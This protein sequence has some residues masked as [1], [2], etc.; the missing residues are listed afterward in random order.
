[1]QALLQLNL[2]IA[3]IDRYDRNR[4]VAL[5]LVKVTLLPGSLDKLDGITLALCSRPFST[6]GAQKTCKVHHGKKVENQQSK[7]KKR[8]FSEKMSD[9]RYFHLHV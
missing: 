6:F 2:R 9:L 1:M 8:D 4:R 5:V 7:M 3:F